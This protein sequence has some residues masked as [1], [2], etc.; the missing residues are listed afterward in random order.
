[1]CSHIV[2]EIKP[3]HKYVFVNMYAHCPLVPS[4]I[5][6]SCSV[7]HGAKFHPLPC[8]TLFFSTLPHLNTACL[9]QHSVPCE[10]CNF[11]PI[12]LNQSLVLGSTTSF[13]LRLLSPGWGRPPDSRSALRSPP[14][15]KTPAAKP[16]ASI[17]Q[18][19]LE[20]TKEASSSRLWN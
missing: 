2:G 12:I 5:S 16:Q 14:V 10:P 19:S 17:T 3:R 15:Q 18:H 6:T 9:F 4:L 13:S 7:L 11:S 1:M 20:R 8:F